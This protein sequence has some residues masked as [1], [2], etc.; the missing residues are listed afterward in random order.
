MARNYPDGLSV[1]ISYSPTR[2]M[3]TASALL[4]NGEDELFAFN[5][6]HLSDALMSLALEIEKKY[7]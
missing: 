3:F 1:E 4:R 5:S 7:E 6:R 2:E